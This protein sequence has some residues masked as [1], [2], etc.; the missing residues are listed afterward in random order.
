MV[1][2]GVCPLSGTAMSRL[3]V[4]LILKPAPP[5]L[6]KIVGGV[7]MLF[8]NGGLLKMVTSYWLT[9]IESKKMPYPARTDVLPSP[10]GSQAR[11][12]RGP[13]LFFGVLPTW[14]PK[15]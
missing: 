4:R 14:F 15:G 5:G 10:Y 2:F 3:G 7:L 11:P 13:K 12:R 8:T 1:V 6:L 9:A